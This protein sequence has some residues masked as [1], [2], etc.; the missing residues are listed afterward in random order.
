MDNNSLKE[1]LKTYEKK[2]LLAEMELDKKK[3]QI[4][5]SNARLRKIDEELNSYAFSTVKH[6]L[7]SPS[8]EYVSNLQEKINNL[9]QEKQKIINSL[10]LDYDLSSPN[11]ECKICNDTGFVQKDG[12]SVFCNCLKQKIFDIE[13]NKSNIGNLEKENFSNFKFNLYSDE[14]NY[15]KY[16]SNI[17]PRENIKNIKSICDKFIKNFEDPDEKNLLFTGNTGLGKTYLS[18]CIAKEILSQGKTVLYQTSSVMLDSIIDYKF[19]KNNSL[20]IYNNILDVDLL[21]IDDLGT[22][23]INNIKFAELFNVIN[24]R[25][26]NQHNHITKTIISTNLSLKNL[27][28]TYDERII[29]RLVGYYNICKFFGEDIRFKK[30]SN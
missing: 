17:S 18:N 12:S 23:S 27:F 24:T 13:Y 8:K 11:Y 22:E 26:L 30:G 21:I 7:N 6:I 25:L 5:S 20:N 15:E 4:Y 10:N 14:I 9:K 1:I 16:N 29:S 3:E 19:G 2:K 28:S